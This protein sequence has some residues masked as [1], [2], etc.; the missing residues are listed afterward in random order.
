MN[1]IRTIAFSSAWGGERY[2]WYLPV[3]YNQRTTT[4]L[5]QL[6]FFWMFLAAQLLL[7]WFVFSREPNSQ[8]VTTVQWSDLQMLGFCWTLL[9][10]RGAWHI[11]EILSVT[12]PTKSCQKTRGIADEK[13]WPSGPVIGI[14][15]WQE[16]QVSEFEDICT[17][18][19]QHAYVTGGDFCGSLGSLHQLPQIPAGCLPQHHKGLVSAREGSSAEE[20]VLSWQL[21][22]MVLGWVTEKLFTQRFQLGCWKIPPFTHVSTITATTAMTQLGTGTAHDIFWDLAIVPQKWLYGSGHMTSSSCFYGRKEM[23]FPTDTEKCR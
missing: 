21:I 3:K 7:G 17:I 20:L 2:I 11:A 23:A 18:P 15:S 14:S 12:W 16:P 5:L 4:G 6:R 1:N 8:F 9:L 10:S 22:C 19:C 13:S